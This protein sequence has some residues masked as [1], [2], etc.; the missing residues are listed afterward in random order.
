RGGRFVALV[1]AG[2]H[3]SKDGGSQEGVANL[4]VLPP[5]VVD[6]L[7]RHSAR[8]FFAEVRL[9][10][11]MDYSRSGGRRLSENGAS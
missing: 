8:C 6:G 9:F 10:L 1:A 2:E 4:H 5:K 11:D 3:G 7:C